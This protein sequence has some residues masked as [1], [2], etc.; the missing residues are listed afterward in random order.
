MQLGNVAFIIW[1][2]SVEALLVIGILNAWL[3]RQSDIASRGRIYLWAGVA[4]GLLVAVVLGVIFVAFGEAIS[5][6]AQ[7]GY[8]T[9]AVLVAAALIIQMVFWMR[10]HGRTLKRELETSLQ[11]AA[12]RSSWWT[13]FV[14]ALIA[15]A[16][17]GSETVVF[18]FGTLSAAQHVSLTGTIV[19]TI[20]GF[21]LAL[22]TYYV[23]QLGSR[24]LSWRVFFGVT[25]IMLLLL[26][27]SLL[28]TGV[29]NLG[30]LGLLPTLSGRLWDS[31]AILPDSGPV[32]GLLAALTGYRARPNLVDVLVYAL[33]W[34]MI[35]SD[36]FV[37][38][39]AKDQH[40]THLTAP[41][42][43]HGADQML[44]QIGDWLMRNQR[45]I[46][47]GQWVV[48]GIYIVLVAVPAF[49]P[50]P[51]RTAHI[52]TNLTLFAQFAFWGVWWPFVLLSMVFVGRMWC[53]LLCPEGALSEAASSRGKGYAVPRWIKWKAWPF[54]AFA[55][56]TIYGQML[57]VYQYPK[58]V[59]V[60][61]GGSTL[62]AVVVG[63]LYGHSKR[64]G[65]AI[66]AL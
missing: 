62:A 57:S 16:R 52:W 44:R 19:A 25:E 43:P 36:S 39:P 28:V 51:Q 66:F 29:E 38:V 59:L 17:E 54:V 49:L 21:S 53:G 45:A 32:G 24:V 47:A 9:G 6:E 33:Y 58:P 40:G 14:L 20:I 42:L 8:Q 64:D 63:F 26:A 7:L 30:E 31:S 1:R 2:E 60:I 50:L 27:G 3:A 11:D 48:V 55:G 46:R 4:A 10:R 15:V 23:L 35:F 22:A 61:L 5:D 41:A 13:I 18:L 34:G 12:T 37:L 65:A 56:T